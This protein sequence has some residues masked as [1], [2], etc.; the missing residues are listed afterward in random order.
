MTHFTEEEAYMRSIRYAGYAQHKR[1]HD[2]F[3]DKTLVSLRNDLERSGYSSLAI[4]RFIGILQ[5]WLVEHIMRD[6]QAIVG[7]AVLPKHAGLSP[8]VVTISKAVD[9]A[10]GM[11]LM[12]RQSLPVQ[13]IKGRT[14]GKGII[15]AAAMTWR[16]GSRCSSF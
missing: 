3:R 11:Y 15:A 2:A 13:I 7:K 8:Q 12:W 1:I 6:D 10:V 9:R 5:R 4:Q 14:L 16:T